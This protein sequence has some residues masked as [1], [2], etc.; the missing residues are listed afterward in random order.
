MKGRIT[1]P[2]IGQLIEITLGSDPFPV[3]VPFQQVT[4]LTKKGKASKEMVRTEERPSRKE[5]RKQADALGID[6]WAEMSTDELVAAIA[7]ADTDD[8][9]P[10][11]KAKKKKGKKGKIV[12]K[13]APR[14]HTKNDEPEDEPAKPAKA[15]KVAKAPAAPAAPSGRRIE[16]D[17]TGNP[18]RKGS[19][20]YLITVELIKG[21]KRMSMIDR[22]NKKID[23]HPWAKKAK[24]LNPVFEMD[25]RMLLTKNLLLKEYGFTFE[26]SG[27]GP[28]NGTIKAFPPGAQKAAA[29]ATKASKPATATKTAKKGK[30]AA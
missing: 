23:L 6:G 20:L 2:G 13:K 22:L 18:F 14:G 10:A 9:E 30:K 24:D 5:L 26:T 21:G 28:E 8:N 4:L 1:G 3:N 16:P 12:N 15:A 17:E 25:K 27:R 19:N 29:K 11:P 7:E